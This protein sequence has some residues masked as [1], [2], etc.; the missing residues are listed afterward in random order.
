MHAAGFRI[1]AN[2]QW[3]APQR[4]QKFAIF[5]SVSLRYLLR[6]AAL[7]ICLMSLRNP[8]PIGWVLSFPVLIFKSVFQRLD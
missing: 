1:T 4:V 7:T 3:S 2:G 5:F 6:F 8:I